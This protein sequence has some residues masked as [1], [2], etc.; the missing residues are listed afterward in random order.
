[1]S[2]ARHILIV[3]TD[4]SWRTLP[5]FAA[6]AAD[7]ATSDVS[8]GTGWWTIRLLSDLLTEMDFPPL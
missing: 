2:S 3:N 5:V 4:S 1:V 6:I 8:C 7:A